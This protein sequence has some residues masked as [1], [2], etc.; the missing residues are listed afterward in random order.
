[1][2]ELVMTTL[3]RHLNPSIRNQQFNDLSTSHRFTL[4]CVYYTPPTDSAL[5]LH[6]QN[7]PMKKPLNRSAAP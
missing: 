4:Q 1:V 5:F 3:Y 6:T 7:I 2:F